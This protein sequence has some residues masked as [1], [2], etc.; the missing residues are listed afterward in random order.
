MEIVG[1]QSDFRLDQ[2]Q[3]DGNIPI[4]N[5]LGGYAQTESDVDDAYIAQLSPSLTTSYKIGMLLQINFHQ[6]NFGEA[7]LNIDQ[8]GAISLRKFNGTALVPLESNDLSTQLIYQLLYDGKAFQVLT[9]IPVSNQAN[10]NTQ[11]V[12]SIVDENINL[13]DVFYVNNNNTYA[14]INR[15]LIIPQSI[16]L[17]RVGGAGGIGGAASGGTIL[18]LPIAQ[19]IGGTLAWTTQ[20]TEGN[21]FTCQFSGLGIL[22]IQGVFTSEIDEVIVNFPPYI[23]QLPLEIPQTPVFNNNPI[24]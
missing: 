24:P 11:E 5:T 13:E 12:V 22:N 14:V 6:T 20:S 21:F 8:Q 1:Y 2:I 3:G 17:R 9:G 23:A 16:R 10:Q 4:Q 18:K 7:T 15:N 19:E